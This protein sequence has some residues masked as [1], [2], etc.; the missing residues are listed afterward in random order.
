MPEL[1]GLK[2]KR[3]LREMSDDALMGGILF[4]VVWFLAGVYVLS[5]MWVRR[6][7][8]HL[9]IWRKFPD[10]A[11]T[12]EQVEVELMVRNGGMLPLP[13]LE[14]STLSMCGSRC[15]TDAFMVSAL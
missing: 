11:F 15:A 1:Q 5:R 2:G 9:E 10:H 6:A 7:G 13:L 14:P 12:G 4:A 3:V 8:R